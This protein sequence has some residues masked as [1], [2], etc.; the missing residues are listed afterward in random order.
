MHTVILNSSHPEPHV[1]PDTWNVLVCGLPLAGETFDLGSSLTLRRLQAPLTVFDLAAAGAVGFRE[2]ATLEPLAA[3]ATGEITSPTGAA[4]APGYDA[5]NKCWLVSALLVIRGFARHI[6]PACSGYSWNFIAGHQKSVAPIFRQQLADE[7]PEKAVFEPRASLPAFQG[8]LL[9]YHLRLLTPKQ[10]R[11]TPFGLTEAT[12][13]ASNFERFNQLAANEERFRFALEAAVDWRYAK[14]P[15]A[16]VA[17]VWAGIES[18]LGISSELVY[19]V[20]LSAAAVVALR[21]PNR[22]AA[23]KKIK[24]MY[25][26]RSKAVHGEPIS[27]DKLFT[28]L[29]DAFEVLGALL[30]DAVERGAMRTEDDFFRELLS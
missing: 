15:R 1:H 11:S 16:A 7:G 27:E 8:G 6:C 19:R 25:A 9:D 17:R 23:F 22:I 4:A 30:L 3:S 14:D 28:G 10:T 12:W 26:V 24:A 5:L 18:L 2:W 13:F 29:H 20:A 21:G